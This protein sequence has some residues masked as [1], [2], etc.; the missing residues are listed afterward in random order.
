MLG[1]LH[2]ITITTIVPRVSYW[3]LIKT[4]YLKNYQ[5]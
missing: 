4:L 2:G 5:Y 3:Q 1:L